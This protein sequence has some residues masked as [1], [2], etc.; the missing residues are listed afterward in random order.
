M[1]QHRAPPTFDTELV[2]LQRLQSEASLGSIEWT[3]LNQQI[4][5]LVQDHPEAKRRRA[6]ADAKFQSGLRFRWPNGAT[7]TRTGKRVVTIPRAMQTCRPPRRVSVVSRPR[8]ARGSRRVRAAGRPASKSPPGE[9]DP[10][11]G[12]RRLDGGSKQQSRDSRLNQAWQGV[13]ALDL[14]PLELGTLGEY[15]RIRAVWEGRWAA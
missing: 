9:P 5:M 15:C 7:T 3:E 10:P 6:A 1:G 4:A 13:L 14:A 8:Q 12:L 11:P 2:R